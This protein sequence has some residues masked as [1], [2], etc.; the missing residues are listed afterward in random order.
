MATSRLNKPILFILGGR[1]RR[2]LRSHHRL[3]YDCDM[4]GQDSRKTEKPKRSNPNADR[5][6]AHGNI[7][8]TREALTVRDT[9][10]WMANAGN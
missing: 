5:C 9:E 8:H 6:V 1:I 2:C 3:R 10:K 4:P 7:N